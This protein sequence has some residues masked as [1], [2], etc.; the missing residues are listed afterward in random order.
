MWAL[1]PFVDIKQ[2]LAVG[3]EG[4]VWAWFFVLIFF[5]FNQRDPWIWAHF[6]SLSHHIGVCRGGARRDVPAAQL[7]GLANLLLSAAPAVML[8][9]YN[10][11]GM[12]WRKPNYVIWKVPVILKAMKY[13]PGS[14]CKVIQK[15]YFGMTIAASLKL[16][17]TS[18]AKK[19][20][21]AQT[22]P[23]LYSTLNQNRSGSLSIWACLGE[24]RHF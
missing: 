20:L 18:S 2:S 23:W 15:R 8:H 22:T 7:W 4:R 14:F 12:A 6:L 3:R 1:L 11:I 5:F 13:L 9:V 21:L 24:N 10:V 19:S 16:L 17:P